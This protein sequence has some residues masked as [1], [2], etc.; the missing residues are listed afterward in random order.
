MLDSMLSRDKKNHFILFATRQRCSVEQ[1]L[2]VTFN[3]NF[4][5]LASPEES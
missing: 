5:L 3:G 1:G 2:V 4:Y